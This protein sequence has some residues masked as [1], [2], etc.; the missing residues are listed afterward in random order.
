[1]VQA[2]KTAHFTVDADVYAVYDN[3]GA[4]AVQADGNSTITINGGN[5][6]Q[7]GVPANDK[8][9]LIYALGNATITINGGTFK[10]A[11]PANTLNVNYS[12]R[13]KA[14]II[15]NGGKFDKYDPSNPTL[16]DNE[17]FLGDGCK[18]TKE[19]DWYVVSK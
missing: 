17:I 14:K 2:E 8:S 18:V 15:G 19:G 9:D 7:V 12:A 1:M 16:G 6:R 11:T 5:F 3:G 4:I 13:G 10:A